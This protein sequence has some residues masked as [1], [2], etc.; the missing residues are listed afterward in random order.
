MTARNY[1]QVQEEVYTPFDMPKLPTGFK[2]AL[3]TRQSQKDAPI[4][5]KESYELQTV[6][7]V[8]YAKELGWDGD[9]IIVFI[10]NKRKDGKWRKASGTLRIDQRQGLQSIVELIE[11]GEVKVVLVWAVD[12]LFR[13]EDMIEPAVF[14]KICKDNG[15]IILTPD[16][17]F[18]FN[19]PK[20]DDRRRFLELAQAAA[21]YITKH[22][23]GRMLPAKN[24]VSR[25]G[26]WDGR[27]LPIGLVIFEGE[28]KPHGFKPQAERII[29][30]FKRLRELDGRVYLLW[31]EIARKRDLFPPYPKE[32]LGVKGYMKEGPFGITRQGLE[33][34]L[35][36]PAYIGH[37]YHK[38]Q[39]KSAIIIKDNH[40]AIVDEDDFWYAFNLLSPTT[41]TGELNA[42]KKDKPPTR[43]TRVG[44]L[45][46]EALLDGIVRSPLERHGVYV[47]QDADS[48]QKATYG[49]DDQYA[50]GEK[51][52]H[53]ASIRVI[54][55][56][57]IFTEKLVYRLRIFQAMEAVQAL[58]EPGRPREEVVY[59]YL[60][61]VQS[62]VD[63]SNAGVKAQ[64]EEYTAE[65]ASLDK[66]LHYGAASLDGKTIERYSQ[67]LAHL[68]TTIEI[69]SKKDNQAAKTE[70]TLR[71]SA[72]LLTDASYG[73]DEFTFENKQSLV[74][75]ITTNIYL[76][77]LAP[78]WLLLEIDW[79]P[80][81]GVSVDDFAFI[82]RPYA[83]GGSW[84]DA[85][86][87]TL[88]EVYEAESRDSILQSFP[89]RSW[90]SILHQ[91]HRLGLRRPNNLGN[92]SPLHPM[93]SYEDIKVMREND[94]E[95]DMESE[96]KK[97]V[98]WRAIPKQENST[99][100]GNSLCHSV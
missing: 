15:V 16:E 51:D 67:R 75:L 1:Q 66:T 86:K 89:N 76:S 74:R 45:P 25:R 32:A 41:I 56:D 88:K 63:Q 85:D 20:R 36:N 18:D 96:P 54:E 4:K 47:F 31:R 71:R 87:E 97:R 90:G 69:L 22:I 62:S 81:L 40:E 24:Q 39:G 27:C 10:E 68:N 48:P 3:Y 79:S 6:R 53:K 52:E 83:S 100:P 37:W 55:L 94:L 64:L 7:L 2:L 28:V 65:A 99:S 23:K 13:H 61:Q 58:A 78:R 38:E 95:Y 43:F 80:F 93:L 44:T 9:N 82:W 92:N 5:H 49:I 30:L 42:L 21:D 59:R 57:R 70:K 14:I 11:A 46:A 33:L 35:T 17:F 91:A 98:W 60:K 72:K 8:E 73:Y 19:N 12:R 34:I 77:V 29:Y 84:L 26:D 50:S